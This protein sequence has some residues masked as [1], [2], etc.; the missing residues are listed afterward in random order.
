[1][2]KEQ[3]DEL[4]EEARNATPGP[5][6]RGYYD[7]NTE[8]V[9]DAGSDVV[10]DCPTIYPGTNSRDARYIAAANPETILALCDQ[11][12]ALEA[13]NAVL[14][15]SIESLAVEVLGKEAYD[16]SPCQASDCE[17]ISIAVRD[18]KARNAEL[19]RERDEFYEQGCGLTNRA[20]KAERER[21]DFA[22][23]VGAMLKICKEA[24]LCCSSNESPSYKIAR[25]RA[26]G[27]RYGEVDFFA[28]DAFDRLAAAIKERES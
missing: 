11:I 22:L 28:P 19:E 20:A 21:D 2:N 12:D 6:S 23:L 5:W 8:R 18:L 25:L 1:M 4:R 10:A 15:K 3:R 16:N 17:L 26:V 24:Q 27:K 13:R 9:Y 14:D 7:I